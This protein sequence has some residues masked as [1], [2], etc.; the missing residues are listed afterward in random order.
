MPFYC[1]SPSGSD[2]TD[3]EDGDDDGWV[4]ESKIKV[5]TAATSR[6]SRGNTIQQSFDTTR[7]SPV[8]FCESPTSPDQSLM[9]SASQPSTAPVSPTEV[10]CHP[11]DDVV[12][13]E[14]RGGSQAV[15]KLPEP[16]WP[17]TSSVPPAVPV[18]QPHVSALPV[19]DVRHTATDGASQLPVKGPTVR[20]TGDPKRDGAAAIAA[21]LS[22]HRPFWASSR[23][24]VTTH[25]DTP[26]S[27]EDFTKRQ[28][29]E[30]GPNYGN[31]WQSD[32][33]DIRHWR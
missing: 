24:D 23:T 10:R 20:P 14:D 33:A 13:P 3:S 29:W 27:F 28:V 18:A 19:V 21:V 5:A 26:E 8:N 6:S 11:P 12:L 9:E 7:P 4:V 25:E 31:L 16:R 22:A 15:S 32:V 1:G 17:S 30:T 2:S